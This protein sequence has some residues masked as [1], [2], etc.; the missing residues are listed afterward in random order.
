MKY[1]IDILSA[2]IGI[3]AS[4]ADAHIARRH[5][6]LDLGHKLAFAIANKA[7]QEPTIIRAGWVENRNPAMDALRIRAS[8]HIMPFKDWAIEN[9]RAG[10]E[11]EWGKILE[12]PLTN[13]HIVLYRNSFLYTK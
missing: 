1:P 9:L 8:I 7:F 13:E 6:Y 5:A 10:Q 12:V 4:G 11:D 2:D 3:S